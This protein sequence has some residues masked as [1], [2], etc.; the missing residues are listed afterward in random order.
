[1]DYYDI[2]AILGFCLLVL[3]VMLW[4]V[5][6]GLITAGTLIILFGLFGAK[7]HAR[8]TISTQ[9]NEPGE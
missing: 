7:S 9:S 2:L 6:A 1:M 8:A 4:S 3:G 5:P